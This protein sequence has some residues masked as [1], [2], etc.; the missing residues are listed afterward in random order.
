MEEHRISK[1]TGSVAVA[2]CKRQQK[3]LPIEEHLKCEYCVAPVFDQ[4]DEPVSFFCAY[5][6]EKKKM[7]PE[8]KRDEEVGEGD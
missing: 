4:D 1:E 7:G 5:D 8:E 3:W 6:E 2:F